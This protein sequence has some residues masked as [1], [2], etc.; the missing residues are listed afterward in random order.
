MLHPLGKLGGAAGFEWLSGTHTDININT[1]VV[2]SKMTIT[3]ITIGG[4]A[5]SGTD[6]PWF[7]EPIVAGMVLPFGAKISAITVTAGNGI[8]LKNL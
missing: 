8:G 3:A 2:N 4:T 1:I 7:G 6:L 5:Y